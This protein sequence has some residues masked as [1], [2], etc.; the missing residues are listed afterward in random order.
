M[1]DGSDDP[2]DVLQYH[3]KIDEG[4]DCVFGTRFAPESTLVD[5]IPNY[6]PFLE[7]YAF[8]VV[9]VLFFASRTPG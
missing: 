9:L 7:N 3:R 2:R 6:L 1:A 4:Y 8:E 5:Y